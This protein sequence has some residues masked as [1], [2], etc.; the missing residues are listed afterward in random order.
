M[1]PGF[2]K[3][4]AELSAPDIQLHFVVAIVEDHARKLRWGHGFSCHVCLLRPRSRGTISLRTADP[5]EPP[6]ID[7]NFLA[8]PD[9]V[10]DM[11]AGFKLTRRL[12]DAPALA[13]RRTRDLFT[14]GVHT[15][16]E[17]RAVL[18]QRVDC[19]Y[20]PV[21]TCKMGLDE[22]AVVDPLLQVRNLTGLR[23]VDCSIMPTL[24]GGNTN[25]PAIMIGEKAAVAIRASTR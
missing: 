15:D 8:H 22:A 23:V 7:P 16:D 6:A 18:R 19:V 24:V 17:I 11:V 20:H 12:M 10:E 5:L 1:P 25:A 2:L 13:S 4:R 14:A 9:D 3:T 21:G